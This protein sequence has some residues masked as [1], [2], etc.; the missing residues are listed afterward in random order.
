[1]V[2]LDREQFKQ[3]FLNLL[4][5]SVQAMEQSGTVRIEISCLRETDEVKLK[6]AESGPG[7][8]ESMREKVFDPFFTTKKTGTGLGLAVVQRIVSAR[9]GRVFI[10]DHP[11]GG[12]LIRIVIPR[13]YNE[14]HT[15]YGNSEGSHS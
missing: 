8:P 1:L 2:E 11:D 13:V 10:E 9:G 6:F 7:I 12:A 5:N 4:I 15:L 14:G 3:V